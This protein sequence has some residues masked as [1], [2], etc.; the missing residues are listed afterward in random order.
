MGATGHERKQARGADAGGECPGWHLAEEYDRPAGMLVGVGGEQAK[1]LLPEARSEQDRQADQ[2]EHDDE[3]RHDLPPLACPHVPQPRYADRRLCEDRDR[4]A[5]RRPH[6]DDG[7]ERQEPFDVPDECD[8]RQGHEQGQAHAQ[9]QRLEQPGIHRLGC[10]GEQ[11]IEHR[12]REERQWPDDLGE[13]GRVEV[14]ARDLRHIRV[15]SRVEPVAPGGPIA[16]GVG[17]MGQIDAQG[18]PQ[19]DRGPQC[20]ERHQVPGVRGHRRS[21]R[22]EP[23]VR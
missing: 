22:A 3:P 6:R 1:P 2:R 20:G 14:G 8:R 7:R 12:E 13:E 21:S 18:Q 15:P 5:R 16:V 10:T 17:A 11:G 4:P 23:P 19:E 9:G